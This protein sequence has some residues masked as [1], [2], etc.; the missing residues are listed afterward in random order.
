MRDLFFYPLAATLAG[1]FI[2]VALDPYAERLPRGPVSAGGRN[3][4]DVTVDGVE[5][6]RFVTGEDAGMSID[7]RPPADGGA[8]VLWIDRNA[9]AT[10]DDPRLGPH[11]VIAEDIEYAMESRPIEVIVE[12]RGAGE[13]PA[14]QFEVNYFSKV[15]G[16]SGWQTF[17]LTQDFQ[18]YAL[19][20][21][22]PQ[23]GGDMGYDYVG[24]RP[25][26]PDKH[27]EME[28]RSVRVRATGPKDTP[29]APSG[30]DLL[31]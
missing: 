11:L 27:R 23:R 1:A 28:V 19:S 7:V 24:I 2:F 8:P 16:E 25:I 6:N 22:T 26:A 29:P 3:V 18:P 13:F 21:F 9:G 4:E 5:L 14:S 12:A 10:Y 30:R 20:F 17:S 31:R 15:E